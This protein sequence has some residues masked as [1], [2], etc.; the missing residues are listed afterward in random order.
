MRI[1]GPRYWTPACH[2]DGPL[3]LRP[4]TARWPS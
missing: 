4:G 2:D 1:I 3:D